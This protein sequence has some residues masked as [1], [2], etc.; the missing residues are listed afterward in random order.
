MA[1]CAVIAYRSVFYCKN[2]ISPSAFQHTALQFIHF[3]K[4]EVTYFHQVV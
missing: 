2:K 3:V 1:K 4:K